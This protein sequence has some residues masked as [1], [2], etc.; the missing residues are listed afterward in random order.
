VDKEE[1]QRRIK[2]HED[3]VIY[4]KA[5]DAAMT[6][7]ELS[8][9]FPVE[10]RY[11]LTD[12]IRRSSR[13]LNCTLLAR[14]DEGYQAPWLIVTDL[15][16]ELGDILWYSLRIGIECGYRDIK[17]DGW[18]WHKTR[19]TDPNRAQRLWLAIAVATLWTLTVG[20]DINQHPLSSFSDQLSSHHL[21]NK[22]IPVQE[23]VRQISGF[24]QG[25]LTIIADLLNGKG[26]CLNGLFPFPPPVSSSITFNSS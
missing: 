15:E 14:W 17:S 21:P 1:E 11:S 2:T 9:Q 8:K 13:S 3:L 25:L 23:T 16:P 5:F 19:L 24:L 18:Q 20:S 6:I 10:E 7:F 12:Q 22:P 4:Q 26:I